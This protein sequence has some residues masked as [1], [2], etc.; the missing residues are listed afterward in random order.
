[1]FT[2][3]SG[4]LLVLGVVVLSVSAPA[5]ANVVNMSTL[6]GPT[7]LFYDNFEGLANAVSHGPYPDTSGD[8]NP[9]TTV[10]TWAI[11]EG[12]PENIQVTDSIASPDPGTLQGKNY[13]RIHRA[14]DAGGDNGQ[15]TGI[16]A[17]QSTTGDHIRVE[18]MVN[19]SSAAQIT[20]FYL[21]MFGSSSRYAIGL[22]ANGNAANG[23]IDYYAPDGNV[24][25]SGLSFTAGTWQKWQVDYNIGDANM[26]FSIGG[27]TP[28]S[29][30]VHSPGD[31]LNVGFN[32]G[33][34]G[35]GEVYVDEAPVPEPASIV[36][37]L[38]GLIGLLAYAWRKR[39]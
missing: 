14:T 37:L 29:L 6:G 28:V 20:P 13:L 4:F 38:T 35:S 24:N 12:S 9:V 33:A 7:T 8:Y 27:G 18:E 16:F 1:M 32:R 17:T 10:G 19:I 36:L 3:I 5:S 31:L 34:I 30:A 11:G 21:T 39:N 15:A 25:A 2:R 23:S 26:L 22:F